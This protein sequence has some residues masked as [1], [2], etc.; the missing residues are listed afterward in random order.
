M[1]KFSEMVTEN[2]TIKN[3]KLTSNM[4]YVNESFFNNYDIIYIV[5]KVLKN[6]IQ[7]WFSKRTAETITFEN[8]KNTANQ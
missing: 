3:M 5:G 7:C 4:V 2:F 6:V 1:V 8:I